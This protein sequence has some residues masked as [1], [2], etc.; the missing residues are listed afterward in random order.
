MY[1]LWISRFFKDVGENTHFKPGLNL[2]GGKYISIGSK[3][4][5]GKNVTLNAWDKYMND[6]FNPIITIGDNSS[7]GNYSHVT[8]IN[9]VII[10]NN[11]RMGKNILISDNV[12]GIS[13][14][15]LLNTPPNYRPLFSKGPVIIKD[16]VLI[17]EKVSVLSGVTIGENSIIGA[18]AVVTKDIPANC[19]V[20]GIPAKVIKVMP[21]SK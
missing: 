8:A 9:K 4:S 19:V 20:G 13:E 2:L 16:G 10:G 15:A 7:I 6:S 3:C 5:I 11:V 1:T 14:T 17:G 18:N 21:G 12:H